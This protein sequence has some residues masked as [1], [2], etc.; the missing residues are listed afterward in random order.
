MHLKNFNFDF[1]KK[2]I[3]EHPLKERDRS[4]LLIVN[5][6]AKSFEEC[7]FY[8][9]HH[10]FN[11]GDVL[12]LNDTEVIPARLWG[13]YE[14]GGKVEVLLLQKVSE[15]NWKCLVNASK[16]TR[17]GQII[18]FADDFVAETIA[19]HEEIPI[20]RFFYSGKFENI[21]KK[22]GSIPLPP[23]IERKVTTADKDSY[24]TVYA[25]HPGAVA[26]PTA[27]LHFTE[28]TLKLI[29]NLGVTI[30]PVTLHVSLGTF[31]PVRTPD[32][33]D[34]K[35]HSEFYSISYD[36]AIAINKAKRVIAV[37]TTSVRAIESAWLRG[38]VRPIEGTTNLFI[39]PGYK[40][41]VTE[42]LITNFHQ[43]QSSLFILTSS[44]AGLDLIQKA[45]QYAIS[46][47]YRLFSYG[48]C[49]LIL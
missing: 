11:E 31:A 40:F 44:F 16:K 48:D 46:Q 22:H 1:P 33:R 19:L 24:Q 35:M 2:L 17:I 7:E 14:T 5:R 13:K 34:H 20:L 36:S 37:G 27:G 43:P 6:V 23:Y 30:A 41:N 39:Y 3:A 10:F 26:A 32:I 9:I 18:K 21:L 4:R 12:V 49:M 47:N 45:Y 38:E 25:K 15:N 42:A 28:R 8:D 29:E